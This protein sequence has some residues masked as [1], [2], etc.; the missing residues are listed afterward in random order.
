[1]PALVIGVGPEGEDMEQS[2]PSSSGSAGALATE[3]FCKAKDAGDY[4][5]AFQAFLEMLLAADAEIGPN[6]PDDEEAPPGDM[7]PY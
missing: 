1:M 7:P 3:A 4:D 6:S 5:G 2:E